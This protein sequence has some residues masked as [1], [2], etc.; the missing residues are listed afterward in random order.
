MNGV[1]ETTTT[2]GTGTLTLLAVTGRPRFAVAGVGSLVPYA[3]KDG[4]NWEWGFGKVG[5]GNTLARTRVTATYVAGAYDSTTPSAIT[6]SG[7][8]ADV[9]LSPIAGSSQVPFRRLATDVSRKGFY[10]PHVATAPS[11]TLALAADRLYL[12]PVRIDD[13]FTISGAWLDMNTAGA[14]ST[15]AR[16]GIYR[17]DENAQPA[18]V[19]AES[20]DIDTSVAANVL[21]ATWPDISLPPDWY[22]IGLVCSGTPTVVA[23]P[24][25]AAVMQTPLGID[26]N[27]SGS[28]LPT[29]GYYKTVASG[30][31]ALPASPT[32]LSK[33]VYNTAAWP[34]IALK[35]S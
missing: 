31:T 32:G 24:T 27:S 18:E 3:I 4:D 7:A 10:S 14:A 30:W 8:A 35:V 6:L 12:F 11:G 5:A 33:F 13:D 28:C 16:I 25:S 17:M 22:F 20:G 1:Y 2:S 29:I 21:S 15:K 9:Y 19:L 26:G 34:A 23:Y